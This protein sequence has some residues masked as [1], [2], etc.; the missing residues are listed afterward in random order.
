MLTEHLVMSQ[1]RHGGSE[2]VARAHGFGLVWIGFGLWGGSR[3]GTGLG[4]ELCTGAGT[5]LSCSPRHCLV[6]LLF[7]L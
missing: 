2:S 7:S 4:S 1:G 5:V 6:L 3:Q